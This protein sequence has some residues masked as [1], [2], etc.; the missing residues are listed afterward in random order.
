MEIFIPIL[1][2][3]HSCCGSGIYYFVCCLAHT[4]S[5]N[6]VDRGP[7]VI[8]RIQSGSLFPEP[9][10]CSFLADYLDISSSKFISIST[11]TSQLITFLS[12]VAFFPSLSH[13]SPWLSSRLI[14]VLM[15]TGKKKASK[16]G[17]L[18]GHSPDLM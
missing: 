7:S 16:H 15:L 13:F 4:L 5:A 11:L 8:S 14:L 2:S 9:H 10:G 6:S 1:R 3:A 18:S 17:A 12:V